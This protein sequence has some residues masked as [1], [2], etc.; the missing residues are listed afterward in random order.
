VLVVVPAMRR[1]PVPVV[2]VVKVIVVRN[3]AVAAVVAVHVVV[4]ARFVVPVRGM[5]DHL[6]PSPVGWS[7]GT[8][9]LS[10][11]PG[12]WALGGGPWVVGPGDWGWIAG[13]WSVRRV[14][15]AWSRKTPCRTVPQGVVP[16]V[17]DLGSRSSGS[18]GT[19]A[20]GKFGPLRG[21]SS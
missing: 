10:N 6:V 4:L 2:Q 17:G 15:N 7:R 12:Q 3:R 13:R 11:G 8:G 18:I 14:G 1:V 16:A 9:V 21:G 19:A 20:R 5:S